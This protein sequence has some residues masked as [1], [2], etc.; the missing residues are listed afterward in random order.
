MA[1]VNATIDEI[2]THPDGPPRNSVVQ[3]FRPAFSTMG[4]FHANLD[5]GQ[6]QSNYRVMRVKRSH[7]SG[8]EYLEI[9][10]VYCDGGEII[11]VSETSAHIAAETIEKIRDVLKR[12]QEALDEP[13]IDLPAFVAASI[14]ER[15]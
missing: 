9:R 4:R 5:A 7:E 1:R 2:G 6:R 12:V 15:I 8:P 11:G 14:F 10:E 13:I 3:E